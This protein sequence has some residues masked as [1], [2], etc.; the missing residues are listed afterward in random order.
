MPGPNPGGAGRGPIVVPSSVAPF[1]FATSFPLS[2][3]PISENGIW[4]NSGLGQSNVVSAAGSAYGTSSAA[5][6]GTT[7]DSAAILIQSVPANVQISTVLKKVSGTVDF[8]EVELLFRAAAGA[9]AL[10][11]YECFLE[12][13]GQY[14]SLV[15]RLGSNGGVEGVDYVILHETFSV[16]TPNDG[17]VFRAT[18]V[19][20]ICTAFLAGVQ[21]WTHDITKDKNNSTVTTYNSGSIGIGFDGPGSGGYTDSKWGFK[22]FSAAGL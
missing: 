20:N 8:Q 15:K 14:L 13:R 2:E 5:G 11:G 7:G 10:R 16:T 19:G 18:L 6:G 12:Q 22:S 21:I 9:T 1:S 17:D 4:T 3:T